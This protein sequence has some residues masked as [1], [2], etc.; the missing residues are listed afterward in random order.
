MV[1]SKQPAFMRYRRLER[2]GSGAVASVYRVQARREDDDDADPS[3][4]EF[5][6]AKI[7]H[8]S[9]EFDA[10][11]RARFEQE[12]KLLAQLEHPNL[13]RVYGL[14]DLSK[15]EE[16][17]TGQRDRSGGAL[18]SRFSRAI[19]MELVEG[20]D[21]AQLIAREAPLSEDRALFIALHLAQGLA[22][23]HEAGLIH[24][25]LKPSNILMQRDKLPKIADFGL[26][27]ATSTAEVSKEGFAV[28]GTPDYM[29]P[30]SVDALAVDA[31]SDLYALGVILY[32]MLSGRPP[33]DAPTP[34]ALMKAHRETP[35]PPLPDS[36]SPALASLTAALLA[37]SPAERPQSALRVIQSIEAIRGGASQAALATISRQGPSCANCG[38]ELIAGMRS[39]LYCGTPLLVRG[40]GDFGVLITGPG[41]VGDMIDAQ[42]RDEL[43][44]WLEGNPFLRLDPGR[45]AKKIPRLPFVLASK[46]DAESAGAIVAALEARGFAAKV[47]RGGPLANADVR[48]KTLMLTG[49]YLVAAATSG[50]WVWF[51][52]L[53]DEME[54]VWF[55][56]LLMTAASTF[57]IGRLAYNCLSVETKH[58][59]LESALPKNAAQAALEDSEPMIALIQGDHHRQ[60]LRGVVLRALDLADGAKEDEQAELAQALRSAV[61]SASR[62]SEIDGQ[63]RSQGFNPSGEENRQLLLERDR[64]SAHLLNLSAELDALCAR[65]IALEASPRARDEGELDALKHHIEALEQVQGMFAMPLAP[66]ED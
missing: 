21:L 61:A 8:A 39:C 47:I 34:W 23:A 50:A 27:R 65:N 45:L 32:E 42:L 58:R 18:E 63:L 35:A 17:E 20:C 12:A 57:L 53:S 25:D 14:I 54:R 7:L 24:R 38:Q 2:L 3:S 49:R 10:Q 46:M 33:F 29:A 40:E 37:K 41:E 64:L 19:L 59:A 4:G 1:T 48:K 6:A 62:L 11:A 43:L 13:L 30:E 56:I 52:I 22:A 16:P 26:A 55:I 9:H 31:R 28:L 36:V 60:A 5:Y 44:L 51:Q 15:T 66:A